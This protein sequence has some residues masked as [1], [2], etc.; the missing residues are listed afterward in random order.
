MPKPLVTK[1]SHNF[2]KIHFR[3]HASNLSNAF[4][5]CSNYNSGSRPNKSS[6][7]T[8]LDNLNQLKHIL[9]SINQQLFLNHCLYFPYH[10]YLL[11]TNYLFWKN[12]VKN[13][14]TRV[15]SDSTLNKHFQPNQEFKTYR[16]QMTTC[17]VHQRLLQPWELKPTKL[18]NLWNTSINSTIGSW[19]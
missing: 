9:Y 11:S 1:N 14:L 12:I 2:N 6:L 7:F 19:N 5:I 3:Y 13:Y 16:N 17:Y 4:S 10:T 18:I 8:Y 15:H